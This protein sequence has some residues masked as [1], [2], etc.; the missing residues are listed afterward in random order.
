MAEEKTA[1]KK[2]NKG[3]INEGKQDKNPGSKPSRE[4]IRYIVRVANK[5]LDGTLDIGRALMGIDGISHRYGKVVANVF[6]KETGIKPSTL[7]GEVP[8]EKVSMIED[9]VM[10]PVNH[11]VPAWMLNRV[12]DFE[13]GNPAHLVMA[14]LRFS[15]RKDLQRL[16]RIKSYRGLRI[17]RG[18]PVRGQ[19]T[20]ST[21][22]KGGIIGVA[23]KEAKK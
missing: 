13:T 4:D 10:N 1:E 5:D 23:K 8:E 6:E 14:D 20:K 19:R 15:L 11:N 7:L 21:F 9:I 3:Q 2:E 22:R 17:A 18:L 16:G 12:N